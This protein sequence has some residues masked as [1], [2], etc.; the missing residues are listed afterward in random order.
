MDPPDRQPEP[1]LAAAA[2]EPAASPGADD[3]PIAAADRS[4]VF[5]QPVLADVLWSEPYRFEFFAALR[6]LAKLA[7]DHPAA[8]GEPRSTVDQVRFRTY[9]SLSFP[10][11]E[12]WD[13]T[14]RASGQGLAEMTV[15]FLGLTGPLGALPRPYSELVI[16]RIRKGDF[17]LRDFLDLFNH[18][19]VQIFAQAGEKYRFY[20]TYELADARERLR[21]QQGE[22]KLRGFLLEERPRIDLFSQLLL[23]LAGVGTPLVRYKDSVR[24]RPAA[25]T[26]LPDA[27]PRYFSGLLS[28]TH[29]SAISLGQ[30]VAEYF[31]VAARI[32]PFIGQWVP[33]PLEYQTC[34]RGRDLAV[35]N[36]SKTAPRP[37]ASSDPRLGRN[38]VVGSRIWEVQGRF[39]VRLGP[40][41]FA[42][43][44]Q[45][46]PVGAKYRSLAHLVRLYAGATFDFD[47]QPVLEGSEVPWC[48]MGATGP[49]AP[50]LGW[51]TWLRN[52]PFTQPVDDAVFRVPDQVSMSE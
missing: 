1:G 9:Q 45:Y 22:Q 17:A 26:A 25:R 46:L 18:R 10:P 5:D 16:Q 50:R 51:N 47:I 30:M 29:R 28:Q 20:L 37:S 38:T 3:D 15:A 19:L 39:R 6:V 27:A 11:S 23:D 35:L 34:L 8:A 33:L 42:Q 49:L 2:I 31:G 12:I 24:S 4:D 14:K 40:L 52:Q 48:Q 32:V 21:R 43:F 36:S 44:E 13:L 7:A 41:S